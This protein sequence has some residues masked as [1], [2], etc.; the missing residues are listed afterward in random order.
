MQAVLCLE[1]RTSGRAKVLI[2]HILVCKTQ[3]A[4][5]LI[6]FRSSGH[7]LHGL[8]R[9]AKPDISRLRNRHDIETINIDTLNLPPV[10]KNGKS[11]LKTSG[12]QSRPALF[13]KLTCASVANSTPRRSP[14]GMLLKQL[15]IQ[16]ALRRK[17]RSKVINMNS[18]I[19]SPWSGRKVALKGLKA[20][21][22]SP[23]QRWPQ[24]IGASPLR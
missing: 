22:I 12:S 2:K 18:P 3:N 1:L 6:S 11:D 5:G 4:M 14:S 8:G 24:S 15:I 10:P 23:P 13:R 7:P 9:K 21:N 20:S 19:I 17:A 16:R